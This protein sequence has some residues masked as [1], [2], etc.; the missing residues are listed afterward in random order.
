MSECVWKSPLTLNDT[1]QKLGMDQLGTRRE[2]DGKSHEP[3]AR[4]TGCNPL[5]LKQSS[6]GGEGRNSVDVE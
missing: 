1:G 3:A 6:S 4:E 5:T 2:I